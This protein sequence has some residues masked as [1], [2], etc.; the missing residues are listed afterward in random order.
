[1]RCAKQ[2]TPVL[3]TDFGEEDF[4]FLEEL[5]KDKD[6]HIDSEV[7]K[8]FLDAYTKIGNSYLPHLPLELAVIK[9]TNS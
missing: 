8:E 6:V 9:L 4:A 5:A 2:L 3:K 1:M 7:L